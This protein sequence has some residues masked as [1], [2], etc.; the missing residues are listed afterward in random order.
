MKNRTKYDGPDSAERSAIVHLL[1]EIETAILKKCSENVK[2]P[3]SAVVHNFYYKIPG[4][5]IFSIPRLKSVVHTLRKE[6]LKKKI[7]KE[8]VCSKKPSSRVEYSDTVLLKQIRECD[9]HYDTYY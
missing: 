3:E 1:P 7:R 9:L 6:Y 8:A 2:D 5:Q 4:W